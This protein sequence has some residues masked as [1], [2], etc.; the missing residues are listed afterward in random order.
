[1]PQRMKDFGRISSWRIYQTISTAGDLLEGNVTVTTTPTNVLEMVTQNYK[2]VN[3]ELRNDGSSN[4]ADFVIYHTSKF[5]DSV[6]ATGNAFWDVTGDHWIAETEIAA[7]GTDTNAARQ[8]FVEKGWTY[9]VVTA[10]GNTGST[11]VI[12]RAAISSF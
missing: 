9:V 8:E 11:D 6:P 12:V 7:V 5:N 3:I 2:N 4:T 1:M 10:N